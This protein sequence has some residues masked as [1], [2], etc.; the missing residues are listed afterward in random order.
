MK[1][2]QRNCTKCGRFIHPDLPSKPDGNGIRHPRGGCAKMVAE[3]SRN[4]AEAA[5]VEATR[6]YMQAK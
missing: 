2:T 6:R 3:I 1:N 4:R 5:D